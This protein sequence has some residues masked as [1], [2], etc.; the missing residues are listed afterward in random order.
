MWLKSK[1]A[2]DRLSAAFLLNPAGLS[3]APGSSRRFHRFN[4]SDF[5]ELHPP[6]LRF[7]YTFGWTKLTLPLEI[8]TTPSIARRFYRFNFSDLHDSNPPFLKIFMNS[9]LANPT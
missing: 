3:T 8:S 1:K 9:G 7:C 4:F 6:F 2:A 5:R